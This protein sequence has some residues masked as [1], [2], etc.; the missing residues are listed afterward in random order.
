MIENSILQSNDSRFDLYKNINSKNEI[1]IDE[2]IV[3][4]FVIEKFEFEKYFDENLSNSKINILY[5]I[6]FYFLI[7]YL[8]TI[9]Q[10]TRFLKK[11][12]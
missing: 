11:S 3:S 9:N 10:I 7:N 6:Y 4:N 12:N 2:N 5:I 8:Y 1:F